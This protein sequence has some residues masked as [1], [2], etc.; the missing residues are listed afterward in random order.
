[1]EESHYWEDLTEEAKLRLKNSEVKPPI[2][3]T[4][5]DMLFLHTKDTYWLEINPPPN[6]YFLGLMVENLPEESSFRKDAKEKILTLI[7]FNQRHYRGGKYYILRILRLLY[8][9]DAN[10]DVWNEIVR[11]SVEFD[12]WKDTYKELKDVR[13]LV[14]MI[15]HKHNHVKKI[16]T[17]CLPEH[18]WFIK[19]L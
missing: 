3:L 6:M 11:L 2:T 12:N 4:D 9:E 1:M 7:P 15:E 16:K 10:E 17:L 8:K 13:A 18:F 19:F 14:W 5:R